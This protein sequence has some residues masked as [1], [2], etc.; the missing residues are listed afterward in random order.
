MGRKDSWLRPWI[1]KMDYAGSLGVASSGR[2]PPSVGKP[3]MSL[4]FTVEDEMRGRMKGTVGTRSCAT[5]LALG[6]PE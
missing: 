1:L 3:I 5:V 2:S 4:E 6:D